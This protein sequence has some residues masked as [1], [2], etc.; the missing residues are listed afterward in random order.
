MRKFLVPLALAGTLAGAPVL[1][2]EIVGPETRSDDSIAQQQQPEAGRTD[3]PLAGVRP[4]AAAPEPSDLDLTAQ[5]RAR[6]G[7]DTSILH[8]E[9]ITEIQERLRA[10]GYDVE[11]TAEAGDRTREALAEFQNDRGIEGDGRLTG[12]TLVALGLF[13]GEQQQGQAP[14]ETTPAAP[15]DGDAP[16]AKQ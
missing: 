15:A 13:D 11:P 2:A 1:A 8:P 7:T 10:A 12:E 16:A 6:A 3:E 14:A 5:A 9:F 4:E